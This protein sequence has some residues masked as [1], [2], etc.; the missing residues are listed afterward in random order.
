MNVNLYTQCKLSRNTSFGVQYQIAFIPDE[1]ARKG[2]CLQIRTNGIWELCWTVS[3]V[4]TTLPREFLP[5][6]HDEVKQHRK[7]TGDAL[8][9]KKKS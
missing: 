9:K 3:E 1:F 6:V 5:D 8:P 4:F 7:N 2:K